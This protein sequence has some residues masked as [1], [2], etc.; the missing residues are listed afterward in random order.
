MK[1]KIA[2][3]LLSMC[4]YTL[5]ASEPQENIPAPAQSL[6]KAVAIWTQDAL[7]QAAIFNG[8]TWSP[9]MGISPKGQTSGA[10]HAAAFGNNNAIAIWKS[11]LGEKQLVQAAA[12]NGKR[13]SN[14]LTVFSSDQTLADPQVAVNEEGRI[15]F[16]WSSANENE[17]VIQFC[18]FDGASLSPPENIS[19]PGQKAMQPRFSRGDKGELIA[20][21]DVI[22]SDVPHLQSASFDGAKW[23][24]LAQIPA[25]EEQ[26]EAPEPAESPIVAE[27]PEE[28][29]SQS[30]TDTEQ[31]PMAQEMTYS[32]IIDLAEECEEDFG[33]CFT[34]C[35]DWH[36]SVIGNISYFRPNSSVLR[37]IYSSAWVKYDLMLLHP[38]WE[39]IYAT[40]SVSYTMKHGRSLGG[41]Q[42]TRMWIVPI[43]LGINY[44]YAW[45][46]FDFYV[47]VGPR[48]FFINIKNNSN[49]VERHD[50][51]SGLG[52]FAAAGVNYHFCNGFLFDLFVDYSYKRFD[53]HKDRERVQ[54][55]SLQ[56]GGLSIGGGIGYRF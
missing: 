19:L 10:P 6:E 50:S 1:S 17:S 37:T 28:T 48:Y 49:F 41:H 43:S 3:F 11:V 51:K 55:E 45:D 52:G 38:I 30:E 4:A 42:R 16:L 8:E 22:E 36:I 26:P 47:G 56:V 13:W 54:R 24:L 21:W 2:L 20:N 23:N 15:F 46:D 29:P 27:L 44:L 35:D 53:F 12:Y 25:L 14:P 9:P 18:V 32:E 40:E 5:Q 33:D 7:I 39:N 34:C 31:A